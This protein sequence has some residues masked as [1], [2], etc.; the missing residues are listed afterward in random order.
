[1]AAAASPEPAKLAPEPSEPKAE[2]ASSGL[3]VNTVTF[4]QLR[5]LGLSVTQATRV[6]AY[7][8]RKDGFKSL[9]DLDGVPGMPKDLLD[10]LKGKLSV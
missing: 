5:G 4:E 8:E 6:I 7:R 2:P 9:D 1:V 10:D 3:D